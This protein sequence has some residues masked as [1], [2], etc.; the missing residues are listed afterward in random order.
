MLL[1]KGRD[2]PTTPGYHT[3]VEGHPEGL[4]WLSF[5]LMKLAAGHA[6]LSF[7][8]GDDE[9]GLVMLEGSVTVT[10]DDHRWER[11]GGRVTVFDGPTDLIYAPT[12]STVTVEALSDTAAVAVCRARADRRLEPF[13][14]PAREVTHEA[15]GKQRWRRDVRDMLVANAE[16]RVVNLIVGETIS[17]PGEWSGYPPHKHDRD[18][19]PEEVAF[20]ELYYYRLSPPSGFGIQAHYRSAHHSDQAYLIE[21][22][23]SFAIPDGY[24]PAV[25]AGGYR[26]YYLWF[27]AG[28]SGRAL[29]PYEDPTHRWVHQ[30][31]PDA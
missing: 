23:D 10:V 29:N 12:H 8:S 15:R 7:S 30:L 4:H 31:A 24:H 16:G 2:L 1:K 20:E 3:V 28:P 26:L 21:D 22:G 11:L 13:W 25:A 19:P 6:P 17:Y 14:V 27:M 9:V 18:Q 5:G